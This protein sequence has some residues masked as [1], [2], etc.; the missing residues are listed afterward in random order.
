MLHSIEKNFLFTGF[1]G[2]WISGLWNSGERQLLNPTPMKKERTEENLILNGNLE[3]NTP[4][5]NIVEEKEEHRN[6]QIF[7]TRSKKETL[8][9][10]SF[11]SYQ[12]SHKDYQEVDIITCNIPNCAPKNSKM[13]L[14]KCSINCGT[15]KLIILIGQYRKS[16]NIESKIAIN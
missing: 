10:L 7:L 13:Y 16:S 8:K 15:Y 4:Q 12:K 1:R 2:M 5:E 11:F 3:E 14:A 9:L 6:K